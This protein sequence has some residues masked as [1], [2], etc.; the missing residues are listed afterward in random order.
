[1]KKQGKYGLKMLHG[2]L[3][4]DNTKP[5][6]VFIVLGSSGDLLPM[7]KIIEIY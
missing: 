3:G 4:N 2:K 6:C 5:L 1:M 7:L